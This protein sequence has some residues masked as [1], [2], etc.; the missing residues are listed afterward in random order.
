MPD[1]R[2]IRKLFDLSRS[3]GLM[4]APLVL[5]IV[6]SCHHAEPELGVRIHAASPGVNAFFNAN[7]PNVRS[8]ADIAGYNDEQR[9]PG[10]GSNDYGAIVRLYVAPQAPTQQQLGAGAIAALMEVEGGN[11]HPLAAYN[12]LKIDNV[13]GP[14][15][16]CVFLKS[17][18]PAGS[19][20]GYVTPVQSDGTTC[21]P[22][23]GNNQYMLSSE[24]DTSEPDAP[25]VAR[26]VEDDNGKPAIGV[27]CG[28][29]P[30]FVF[31]HL[32]R[33]VG[34]GKKALGDEQDLAIPAS[35]STPPVSRTSIAGRITPEPAPPGFSP[36]PVKVATIS[37]SA[38]P[39]PSVPSKYKTWGLALGDNGVWI[40]KDAQNNWWAQFVPGTTAPTTQTM[41]RITRTDHSGSSSP[42]VPVA[43]RWAWSDTDEDVWVACDQGCCTISG[44]TKGQMD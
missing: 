3:R 31:C 18:N 38:A 12:M 20:D 5:T 14:K 8:V 2:F 25:Y 19:Y 13:A 32:G 41:F 28:T 30:T 24:V 42:P 40:S 43:A 26:F 27:G 22:I 4:V 36:T 39:D 15:L 21:T 10:D 37:L 34:M 6:S 44:D 7:F 29:P 9:L 33:G 16:Y 23:G 17:G 1:P 11:G 35:G